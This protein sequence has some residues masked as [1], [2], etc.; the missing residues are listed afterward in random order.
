ML[1]TELRIP[2]GLTPTPEPGE[3]VPEPVI[4]LTVPTPETVPPPSNTEL[5]WKPLITAWSNVSWNVDPE[6]LSVVVPLDEP[7]GDLLLLP[8]AASRHARPTITTSRR[9]R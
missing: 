4:P 9:E 5:C 1:L 6:P 7:E 2:V 8:H 3:M